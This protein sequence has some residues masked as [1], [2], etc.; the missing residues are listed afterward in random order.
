[1]D[2]SQIKKSYPIEPEIE[3]DGGYS[4]CARCKNELNEKELICPKCHQVQD[5]SWLEKY[6]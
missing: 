3:L 5:W 1:M 2:L 4:Y 6:K